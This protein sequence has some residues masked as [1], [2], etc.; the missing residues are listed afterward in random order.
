MISPKKH[1][2]LA[3]VIALMHATPTHAEPIQAGVAAAVSGNINVL[4]FAEGIERQVKSGEEIYLGDAIIS[5]DGAG[6]QILLLDETVFTVGADTE[7]S[8][9]EFDYNPTTGAGN[10]TA[11]LAKGVLRFVTGNIAQGDPED[12]VVKLPAGTIGI[13]GTIGVAVMD[14]E[15]TLVVLLGLGGGSDAGATIGRLEVTS[16]GQTVSLTRPQFGTRIAPGQPPSLPFRLSATEIIG[17]MAALETQTQSA[18]SEESDLESGGEGDD[19]LAGGLS[20][21]DAQSLDLLLDSATDTDDQDQLT[22]SDISTFEQLSSIDLEIVNFSDMDPILEIELD[23]NSVNNSGAA[24]GN[25][26]IEVAAGV[27][28]AVGLTTNDAS[29]LVCFVGSD[30]PSH[31]EGGV[32]A[33]AA[34]AINSNNTSS[35]E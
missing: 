18:A 24:D 21:G 34:R 10:V 20:D 23:D 26:G 8:V 1:V 5:R 19:T 16:G 33:A 31:S 15:E 2:A 7:F 11:A 14:G 9:N 3:A 13:R 28:A 27:L 30:E 12:M 22:L 35:V 32:I 4:S 29:C 17:A 6:M 25:H